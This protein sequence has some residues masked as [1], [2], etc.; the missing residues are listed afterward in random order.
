M[1]S[2]LQSVQDWFGTNDGDCYFAPDS[3]MNRCT[4]AGFGQVSSYSY[5]W[6]A[7]I[8]KGIKCEINSNGTSDCSR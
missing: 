3:S 7:A 4:G 2:K 5:G 8:A 6:I 1:R